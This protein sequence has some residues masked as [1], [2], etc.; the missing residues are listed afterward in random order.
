MGG[1]AP[2]IYYA[3]ALINSVK[4][5]LDSDTVRVR[6][7]LHL[8]AGIDAVS[9]ALMSLMRSEVKNPVLQHRPCH[10]Y[11]A[12]CS[13]HIWLTAHQGIRVNASSYHAS[14]PGAAFNY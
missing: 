2:T 12:R 6:P 4:W 13:L 5:G 14:C 10:Y 3:R 11:H 1:L 7:G 9:T 8:P